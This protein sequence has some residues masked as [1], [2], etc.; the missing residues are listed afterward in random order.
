M[1]TPVFVLSETDSHHSPEL[2]SNF[3]SRLT[4]S[5]MAGL[6][7][8]GLVSPL[9]IQDL[10]DLDDKDKS[11]EI[12][13]KFERAWNSVKNNGESS[14]IKV[15][16][17][18]LMAFGRDFM[19]SGVFLLAY[20][21]ICAVSPIMIYLLL[22]W[23]EA[24]DSRVWYPFVLAVGLFLLQ[25]LATVCYNAQ[26]EL[27]SRTGYRLR[28]ALSI[29]LFS[30]YFK[31]SNNARQIYSVGKITNITTTDTLKIDLA[32]QY[33]HMMHGSI[34][35]ILI[36]FGIL[37]AFLGVS[38]FA[39][40][41][42][43]VLYLPVQF[44]LSRANSQFRRAANVHADERMRLIH[45]TLKGIR[46]IK[47]YSWENSFMNIIGKIREK[48]SREIFKYLAARATTS[49]LTQAVPTFAMVLT[50]ITYNFIGNTLSISKVIPSLAL[51]Y[52]IRVPMLFIPVAIG[53]SLDAWIGFTRIGDLLN[54]EELSEQPEL[55]I[56]S[57]DSTEPAIE[58]INADF[59]W[60]STSQ[61]SGMN[62]SV[63]VGK[64][65]AIVGSIGSGKSSLLQALTG[66]MQ[67]VR[68]VVKMRGTVSY[69]QQQAWITNS[70]LQ[71][72]ILFGKSFD[73]AKYLKV[74]R[75]C[76]L[77]RDISILSGGSSAEIGENG[78]NL[79]GGQKQRL[80]LARAV[81]SDP[82]IFLFD[83]PLS[84]VDAH[85]GK[86]LFHE[87][88]NGI[89]K[90]KTRLL[91][92]HQLHFLDQVDSIIMLQEGK[93]IA[94]GT[95]NDLLES[96]SQFRSLILNYT[97]LEEGDEEVLKS[98]LKLDIRESITATN[99]SVVSKESVK[100]IAEPTALIGKEETATGS[101]AG[102][103]Y[104]SYLHLAG[105]F[106]VTLSLAFWISASNVS[107]G[108]STS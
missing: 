6:F 56:S 65:V 59:A 68:G 4:Y 105:G 90:G 50:F 67:R 33:F 92:T 61:L 64:L 94:E 98:T 31:L 24:P 84:A 34:I 21:L 52:G 107:R 45:E 99:V 39:G 74:L 37:Y 51:F 91:V 7:K 26:F 9:S 22:V 8:R 69:C 27:A 108:Y 75:A 1:K 77:E 29:S 101:V 71:D 48:E 93:V 10:Y 87:C 42:F 23:L 54:A 53:Y 57:T 46:V 3:F 43:I 100:V 89:L 63:P 36:T 82:D 35:L 14:P 96:S 30:K 102:Y 15:M 103:V 47:A 25:V 18:A 58:V 49:N 80:S 97:G 78:I 106:I 13:R 41:A 40:F 72:N 79:S 62:F 16:R 19:M 60:N 32:S 104:S 76:S 2:E 17:A 83:D 86:A 66:D 38:I 73:Q 55:L 12:A 85:V 88:I 70:S 11:E 95:Y 81:Y 28:T 5:W 20:N 44:F